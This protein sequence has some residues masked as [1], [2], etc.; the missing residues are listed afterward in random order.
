MNKINIEKMCNEI[1][2]IN[3]EIDKNQTRIYDE[4]NSHICG[5]EHT[6]KWADEW[7]TDIVKCLKENL[8]SSR[9]LSL[10]ITKIE[11]AQLWLNKDKMNKKED[12]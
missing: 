10:A 7:M 3:N 6:Y 5:I 1:D 4:I 8:K 11:E 2:E 12:N 9:E